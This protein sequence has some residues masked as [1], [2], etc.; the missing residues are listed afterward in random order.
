M[1][2]IRVPYCVAASAARFLSIMVTATDVASTTLGAAQSE[3][4]GPRVSSP[5]DVGMGLVDRDDRLR[6]DATIGL[7]KNETM[8]GALR[9]RN[10]ALGT[11]EDGERGSC[12]DFAC[13]GAS[14]G[15]RTRA[16]S[17]GSWSSTIELHS[18]GTPGRA[19]PL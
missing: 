17:L 13:C 11:R 14:D 9:V 1:R 7:R 10:G 15:N 6:R 4:R 19:R 2:G 3:T 12:R 18:R 5:R 8:H 16:T